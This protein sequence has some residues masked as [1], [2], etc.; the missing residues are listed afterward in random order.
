MHSLKSFKIEGLNSNLDAL[1]RIMTHGKFLENDI[2][3]S[4]LVEYPELL[5][6]PGTT[7][8]K[9]AKKKVVKQK[10]VRV[11]G[12]KFLEYEESCETESCEGIKKVVNC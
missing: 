12:R 8:A 9:G 6:L 4:F 10:V 1:E 3:T 11:W 7:G 5:N 2:N